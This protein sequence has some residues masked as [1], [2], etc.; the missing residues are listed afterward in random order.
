MGRPWQITRPV[1]PCTHLTEPNNALRREPLL[2]VVGACIVDQHIQRQLLL[3]VPCSKRPAVTV[4]LH[5]G[6]TVATLISKEHQEG[7]A[8]NY[9]AAYSWIQGLRN[10]SA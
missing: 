9:H 5:M 8:M 3:L 4:A 6:L 10:F 2:C 1:R 7:S